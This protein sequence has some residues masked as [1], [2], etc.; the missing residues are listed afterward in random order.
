MSIW[1][2]LSSSIN[3]IHIEIFVFTCCHC[4][5]C[6]SI[7]DNTLLWSFRNPNTALNTVQ[8]HFNLYFIHYWKQSKY[9]IILFLGLCSAFRISKTQTGSTVTIFVSSQCNR[10]AMLWHA[11]AS[12][13]EFVI[14]VDWVH[15]WPIRNALLQFISSKYLG[16][17]QKTWN[18]CSNEKEKIL[19]N[20]KRKTARSNC[21]GRV[22]VVIN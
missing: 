5:V 7:V 10:N 12:N 19:I 2:W 6:C 14:D 3:C 16:K 15:P 20:K 8:R 9:Y 1:Y 18:L 17:W 21:C 4:I 11:K 22:C 13:N